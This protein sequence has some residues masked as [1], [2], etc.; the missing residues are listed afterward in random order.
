MAIHWIDLVIFVIYL[1]IMLGI[2]FYF[3]SKNESKEDFY[4]GNREMSSGHIGLSVAATDVGGGFSIGL[5]GLGFTMGIS[6]SWMLFT[7]I[8]GAWLSVVFL[9]PKVY[10]LGKKHNFLSFPQLLEFFYG[11]RPALIAGVISFIGYKS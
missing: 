4:V 9:I 3:Y 11:K 6:G 5:G 10:P 1:V 8:I 7:G 2:G